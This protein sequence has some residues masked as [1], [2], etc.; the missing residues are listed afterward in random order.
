M[1]QNNQPEFYNNCSEKLKERFD[2][3]IRL[4]QV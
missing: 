2:K 1:H 4:I 3:T